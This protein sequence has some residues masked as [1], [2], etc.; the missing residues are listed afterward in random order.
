VN[1]TA[2]QRTQIQQTVLASSN[3]PRVN[4]VNFALS[5]GTVVPTSVRVIDVAPALIEINPAWRGH[6]YFVVRDDIVIVDRS[7]N[8]VAVV[9][10]GSSGGGA[11]LQGGV[12][13]GPAALNLTSDQIR[14]IQIVLNEKGFN[15]GQPDGRLG[16]RTT[17]A[18][19]AFQRQQGFQASGHI[20]NQ[21]IS[22]LGLSNKIGGR[23]DAQGAGQSS[24]TG[25]A[26]SS[27]QAPA[28]QNQGAN[29]PATS[30][31]GGANQQQAPA[32]QNQG[33][34]QPATSGQGGANQQQAPAQQNQPAGQNQ[35]NSGNK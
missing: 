31:Q 18:V 2:Q 27:Q 28:Q 10:A 29:Q 19:M 24:T 14:E 23:G 7:R 5:V 30:G 34:N 25:Q 8:I 12:G 6:Q 17:Q 11:Q 15:I 33:A 1:L 20:D 35:Q 9:P 22:A 21:T 16:P 13:P 26:G 32:Q 3:V 4:N